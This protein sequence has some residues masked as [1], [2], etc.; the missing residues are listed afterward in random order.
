MKVIC[1]VNQKGGVGKTASVVNIGAG[2]A[3]C[4]RRVLLIDLDPQES[5]SYW[6]GVGETETTIYELLAG[7]CS[8]NECVIPHAGGFD[9]LPSSEMLATLQPD[10][11]Q[12]RQLLREQRYDYILLDCSPTLGMITLAALTAADW[13]VIPLCPDLLSL[14]GM[15]QL[16]GTIETIRE[17]TNPALLLRAIVATR[18]SARKRM[19][20]EVL[21][22]VAQFFEQVPIYTVRENIAVAESPV[23][24]KSVLDYR[25]GSAGAADY[26]T[27]AREMANG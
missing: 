7:T 15:S 18:Y 24:G 23:S 26:L 5:L 27:I 11:G 3:K 9:I 10:V 21:G 6:L 19:H 20:R 13:V 8:L 16:L 17:Q 12:L 25:P 4:G 22:Q 14:K 2:L 1:F